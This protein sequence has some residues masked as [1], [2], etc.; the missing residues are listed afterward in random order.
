VS[1]S[2]GTKK[3][4][5]ATTFGTISLL[6]LARRFK[7]RKGRKKSQLPQCDQADF[8]FVSP[9]AAESDEVADLLAREDL[10]DVCLRDSISIASNDSFVSAAEC[11]GDLDFLAKLHCVR[12]ACEVQSNLIL[13]LI[14][15]SAAVLSI[16]CRNIDLMSLVFNLRVISQMF[17]VQGRSSQQPP[18]KH[19]QPIAGSQTRCRNA[20]CLR[21]HAHECCLLQDQVLHFLKD[22]FDLDKV[23]YSS[24]ETLAE[25][26][27]HL[28]HRRSELLLAY[29]GP[30]TLRPLSGCSTLQVQLV[31]SA[32]LEAQ[33]Q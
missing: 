9:A 2:T 24:V 28:L 25:D 33:A 27:L 26:M 20:T 13:H 30:D 18:L 8:K 11:V 23:R 16:G 32:L 6:L 10:D 7:R 15:S 21:L 29:L 12:Q 14:V 5:A 3:L 1:V 17:R 19:L 22:V 31:P 4:V